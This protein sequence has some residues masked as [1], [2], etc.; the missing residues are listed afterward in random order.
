MVWRGDFRQEG[1]QAEF[2]LE[3]SFPWRLVERIRVTGQGM[4]QQ[5]AN[6][7]RQA[8]HRPRLEIKPDWYY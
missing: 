1:K 3:H 6:V 4:A 2:L 7:I 5:V 8:A